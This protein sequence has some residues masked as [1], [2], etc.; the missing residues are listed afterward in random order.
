MWDART[1]EELK[2]EPIP[3]APQPVPIS[4][5]GRFFAHAVGSRVELIRLQPDAEEMAYRLLQAQPNLVRYREGYDAA[6]AAKDDFAS[7]FYLNLL[8]PPERTV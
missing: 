3:P 2:D 5:G 1:G 8:P 4:P 6:R 7:R